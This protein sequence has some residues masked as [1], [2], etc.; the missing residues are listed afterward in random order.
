M[1]DRP[2]E[3]SD[4]PVAPR[5]RE[6]EIVPPPAWKPGKTWNDQEGEITTE[7]SEHRLQDWT[8]ILN[9][10]GYPPDEYEIVEPVKV[11]SWEAPTGEGGIKTLWSYK[12]GVRKRAPKSE[13]ITYDDLVREIKKH[14]P[15]NPKVPG[16]TAA[17]VVCI[18]D[19]QF[20]KPDGDGLKGTI[21]RFKNA[22]DAIEQRI[23]DLRTTGRDLGELV[24]A[25]LGD[26]IEGC[27]GNYA[28]QTYGVEINR[29]TQIRIARR[30]I[31]DA[32]ARWSKMFRK[33]TV[34]AVPGNHGENRKDGKSFTEVGD[35]DD[36]AVF[37]MLAEA[38]SM[39]PEAYGHVEFRIPENE[40]F[41]T[42]DAC[43]TA[44]GFAH[45]HITKGGGT[46]QSRIKNWWEE[47]SFGNQSIG[48]VRV[49]VTGHYHH[50][51]IIEH[52]YKTHIQCPALDGGSEWWTNLSGAES[53][54]GMLSF[55][56]GDQFK[57][58]W[59]DLLV[60]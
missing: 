53:S 33:V 48:A 6:T 10:W 31:R 59:T 32:I 15:L 25:G 51:S 37:E 27:D 8:E 23:K 19:P 58:G 41:V 39:N 43:G 7:P 40:A 24:V 22:I 46:P 38:F 49:L 13:E 29:R 45:G 16:G 18:A 17:F 30:L 14:R 60:V 11:S 2:V 20:G 5:L 47:Q 36:V 21:E 9:A 34:V 57:G 42:I 50:T 35:N 54:P 4:E 44:V 56:A 1:D 3:G 12:A 28:S 26:I 55:V 52:G